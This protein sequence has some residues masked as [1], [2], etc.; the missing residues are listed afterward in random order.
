MT[1]IIRIESCKD[2]H[3]RDHNGA[4]GVIAYIPMCRNGKSRELPYTTSPSGLGRQLYASVCDGIPEWCPLE[5]LE[6]AA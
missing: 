3:F 5:K 6:A 4:F 1:R 2:C